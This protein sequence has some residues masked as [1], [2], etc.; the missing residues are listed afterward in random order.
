MN[1]GKIE[2][3][4]I[5]VIEGETK[6][7]KAWA[8]LVLDVEPPAW[9]K[10]AERDRA[11]FKAFGRS[12]GDALACQVGDTVRATFRLESREYQGKWYT[13][14]LLESVR[15]VGERVEPE[16]EKRAPQ[17]KT[18]PSTPPVAPDDDDGS[19]DLPF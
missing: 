14:A 4:V 11:A 10:T 18:R 19:G 3:E 15:P 1:E 13:D 5:A 2:G 8:T 6:G 12:A 17:V 9:K 16:R 7:G